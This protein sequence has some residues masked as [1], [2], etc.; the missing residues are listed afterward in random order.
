[1][2]PGLH[3]YIR[4][5]VHAI[6]RLRERSL[7]YLAPVCSSFSDMCVSKSQRTF[8]QPLGDTS[9]NFV[10]EGNI[11]AHRQPQHVMLKFVCCCMSCCLYMFDRQTHVCTPRQGHPPGMACLPP[12]PLLCSRTTGVCQIQLASQMAVLCLPHPRGICT[13]NVMP[14]MKCKRSVG[15]HAVQACS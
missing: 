4:H 10:I 3:D 13:A 2:G 8:W 14:S 12:W 1:M 15:S 6:L 7:V 11:L 5:A 9:Q